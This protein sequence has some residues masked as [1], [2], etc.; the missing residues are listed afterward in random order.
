MLERPHIRSVS[1]ILLLAL[2]FASAPTANADAPEVNITAE[3]SVLAST[4][5]PGY[6]A[7]LAIDGDPTTSWFSTGPE[8]GG[9]PTRFQWTHSRDDLITTVYIHGNSQNQTPSFRT[10]YGFGSVTVEVLDAS[11]HLVFQQTAP[12]PGNAVPDVLV[13]PNVVGRTV[14]LLLTGHESPDCG[15]F[16]E[17]QV[18]ANRAPRPP[19]PTATPI[20]PTVASAPPPPTPTTQTVAGAGTIIASDDL[21][22][23]EAG[24]CQLG[25]LDNALGGNRTL[26]YLPLFPTGGT[27]ASNPIGASLVSGALQNNGL[28]YGGVQFALT[29]PCGAPIG[30]VRGADLGQDLNIR[31]D[32]VAPSDAAGH[33]AQAG[34]YIRSRAAAMGDEII[35]GASAGYWV[36]LESTGAVTIKRLDS[37]A[38]IAFS[39]NPVSFDPAIIHTLEIAAGGSQ[40]QVA[41]D[42]RLQTFNQSG[43]LVTAVILAPTAGSNDGTAG[44]VFGAEPNRG[45]IGGQRAGNILI[46]AFRPLD[47]L[48][49]Q[50]NPGVSGPSVSVTS[51]P[52]ASPSPESTAVATTVASNPIPATGATG[53]KGD[54]DGDGKLTELDALCALEISVGLRP[55]SPQMDMDGDG[56]VTSRDAVIILRNA[57]GN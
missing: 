44:I 45:Q 48:P 12:G 40:L 10:G 43:Q 22:R 34:P 15:G 3:G 52:G 19:T 38:V 16:S 55:S 33:T 14:L 20:P 24:K 8:P 21:K 30:A 46:T 18:K 1:F 41:L 28:D 54:C 31:V 56:S 2:L 51:T 32:L 42:G 29:P 23:A 50:S 39:G 49:V 7:S 57:V 27:D 37:N 47:G 17:F 4:T 35:G 6:P 53:V 36:R 13:H 5:S 26:Y 9:R 25:K 11:N